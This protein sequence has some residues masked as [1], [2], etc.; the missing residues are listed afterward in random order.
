MAELKGLSE[1]E[2]ARIDGAGLGLVFEN[3]KFSHG[4]DQPDANGEQARIFRIS[5]IKSTDGRDVDITVNHLYISGTGSNYGENLS[6]VNLGR[7]AN[8]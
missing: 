1:G 6:P 8:P 4:T 3:F 7:L 2:M 5:G